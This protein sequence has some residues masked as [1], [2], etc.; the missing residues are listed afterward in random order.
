M[1]LGIYLL[2]AA[3]A[4]DLSV[5]AYPSPENPWTRPERLAARNVPERRSG[6]G[7]SN[8]H[9]DNVI[10]LVELLQPNKSAA[11]PYLNGNGN[12]PDRYARAAIQFQ[13]TDEPYIQ[14]YMVGPLPISSRT[15]LQPL[16]YYYNKGVGKQRVYHT[17]LQAEIKFYAQIGASVADITLDLWNGTFMGLANDSIYLKGFEPLRISHRSA[18]TWGQFWGFPIGNPD[19]RAAVLPLGLYVKVDIY[20]RDPSKWSVHGWFYN[21]IFYR[22]TRA[23]R[24]AYFSPGFKKLGAN[25]DGPWAQLNREG[26][27]LPMDTVA[28]PL[29]VQPEGPRFGVDVK[30][31]YVEWMD[32]SFYISFN[33]DTGMRLFDIKF[34]GER[35][36]YELGLEEALSHYASNDPMQSGVAFL[37]TLEGFGRVAFE[38]VQGYDCPSHA[39]FLNTSFFTN[40]E[41][42]THLNSI[43]LFEMDTGHP[44]QR[45]ASSNAVSVTKSMVFTVRSVSAVGN[46]DFIFDYEF[47]L[48]GSIHV[49]VRLSGYIQAAYWAHNSDYGFKIHDNLSGSM[50]DHVINYKLDMDVN[51]TANS[52]MKTT[53]VPTKERYPWS[54]GDWV[55][56][57]KLR[58]SFVNNERH[59]KINWSPNSATTY[60]VVNKDALNKYGEYRGYR[61]SPVTSSTTFLTV[62]D[63]A[64]LKKSGGWATHNLYALKQKDTEL[65]SASPYNNLDTGNPVVNFDKYFDGESLDQEDL[66]LYDRP[67]QMINARSSM[68]IVPQ[69][70]HLDNPSRATRQQV[71]VTFGGGKLA[72]AEKFGSRHATCNFDMNNAAPNLE[73]YKGDLVVPKYPFLPNNA[74]FVPVLPGS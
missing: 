56:T 17:D 74:T 53:V 18:V 52:L 26:D 31:K 62:Q 20:G 36:I 30:E 39:T 41:T 15:T 33:R 50:H 8:C 63:S 61:I 3:T 43:C 72:Q 5:L 24:K 71:R 68:A 40:E 13:A 32:F 64:S 57:M 70:F 29:Q 35:I 67:P 10:A 25:V 58:K 7:L 38:L 19:D 42:R 9:W 21:G 4:L 54:N 22:N 66:V 11:L 49:T 6:S 37:D 51:G 44:L 55:N 60:T 2:V 47:Y 12:A 1:Q 14:D 45:Y 48:D 28:A 16:N 34:R 27:P 59:S 69:N 46:Y 23:F 73:A 65:H